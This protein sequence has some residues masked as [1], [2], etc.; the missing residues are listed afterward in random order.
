MHVCVKTCLC[1]SVCIYVLC[2]MWV[3]PMLLCQHRVAAEEFGHNIYLLH[4]FF[5]LP[6]HPSISCQNHKSH[7]A[8]PKL[9]PTHTSWATVLNAGR[10]IS[11]IVPPPDIE[12]AYSVYHI[13]NNIM[14]ILRKQPCKCLW[15]RVMQLERLVLAFSWLS[16]KK[17]IYNIIF[18]VTQMWRFAIFPSVL[19]NCNFNNFGVW[20][21]WSM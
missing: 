8:T 21:C 2:S 3:T 12:Y 9:S 14:Y 19:Y 5:H 18:S 4:L 6:L 20:D 17:Y 7:T 11:A 16:Q 15:I 1:V 10:W 13:W